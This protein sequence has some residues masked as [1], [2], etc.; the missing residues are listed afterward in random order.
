MIARLRALVVRLVQDYRMVHVSARCQL[1]R[2]S[3]PC[4]YCKA[5]HALVRHG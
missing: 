5:N 4:G 2:C 3:C 1:A